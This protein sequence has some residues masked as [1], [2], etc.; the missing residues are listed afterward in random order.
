M[1]R[2]PDLKIELI[3]V[4]ACGGPH[5]FT[6]DFKLF[7]NVVRLRKVALHVS[8]GNSNIALVVRFFAVGPEFG[9]GPCRM[10]QEQA[11][12]GKQPNEEEQK[13]SNVEMQFAIPALESGP[14]SREIRRFAWTCWFSG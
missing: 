9:K 13:Q 10:V 3:G 8:A 6:F 14:E 1:A 4:C 5:N 12:E 2:A 7:Q 11:A